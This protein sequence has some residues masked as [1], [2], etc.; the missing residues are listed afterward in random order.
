MVEERERADGRDGIRTGDETIHSKYD[1]GVTSPSAAV[2]ESVATALDR[3]P[4]D[5][6]PLSEFIEPDA[7]DVIFQ[8]NHASRRN[9]VS[10]SFVVD[11]RHVTVHSRGDVIVQPK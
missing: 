7:L 6:D 5:G 8:S 11:D 1:W 9:D 4:T 10:I 3:E 2:V